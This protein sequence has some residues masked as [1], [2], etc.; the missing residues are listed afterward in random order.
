LTKQ[1]FTSAL[2]AHSNDTTL[3]KKSLTWEI[4]AAYLKK[5]IQNIVGIDEAGRG[6]LAGPVVAAAVMFA[7]KTISSGTS[8]GLND[9]KQLVHSERERL[10]DIICE[11][12]LS[13]GI[14]VASNEE[15]DSMNILQATMCAMTRATNEMCAKLGADH[16]PQIL[17]VDGK[18]FRTTLT[19]PFKTF[20]GGDGI[21]PSIAA[22]SIIAKV[23]RDRMMEKL[24]KEYPEYGFASHKG[25]GTKR[26]IQAITENGYCALHRRSFKLKAILQEELFTE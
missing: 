20:V 25:Y 11:K 14:G 24:D 7:P 10:F 21:L 23:T 26:H 15:V 19:F 16:S 1:N 17:L 8:F 5:G 2:Q 3:K 13:F 6:P 18:Y 22:A 4:E 12:A 9:S